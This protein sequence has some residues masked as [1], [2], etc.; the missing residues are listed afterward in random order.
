MR[1]SATLRGWCSL[2]SGQATEAGGWLNPGRRSAGDPAWRSAANSAMRC[3]RTARSGRKVPGRRPRGRSARRSAGHGRQPVLALA[4]ADRVPAAAAS[5]IHSCSRLVCRGRR[6]NWWA[7]QSNRADLR[8]AGGPWPRPWP[9]WAARR[10]RG[11]RGSGCGLSSLRDAH[12]VDV[13]GDVEVD[14]LPVPAGEPAHAAHG[15][16]GQPSSGGRGAPNARVRPS[17]VPG[18]GGPQQAACSSVETRRSTVVLASL[19]ESTMSRIVTCGR[20]SVSRARMSNARWTPAYALVVHLV[21]IRPGHGLRRPPT[22]CLHHSPSSRPGRSYPAK[23]SAG[24][25]PQRSAGRVLVCVRNVLDS[26][27]CQIRRTPVRYTQSVQR[28]SRSAEW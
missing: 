5:S 18:R 25:G 15:L 9:T 16:R 22:R 2:A 4:V 19:V 3:S 8:R 13:A 12:A 17:H 28:S 26:A 20:S 10:R 27:Y 23:H 1:H 11:P 6:G 7:I 14:G 24:W 21:R